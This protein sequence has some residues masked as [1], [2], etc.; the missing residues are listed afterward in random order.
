VKENYLNI[1]S[2]M[3]SSTSK[4]YLSTLVVLSRRLG[5]DDESASDDEQAEKILYF[6]PPST[7][8]ERQ[9]SRVTMIEGLIEFAGK[10]SS[11]PIDT[12]MMEKQLWSFFPAEPDVWIV[13]AVHIAPDDDMSGLTMHRADS[14][15]LDA[16]VKKLYSFI[17]TFITAGSINGHI[18]RDLERIL[19]VKQLRKRARKLRIRLRQEEQD[20]ESI[21]RHEEAKS[22]KLNEN[23]G[24]DVGPIDLE[25]GEENA[26]D[27]REEIDV[28]HQNPS[29]DVKGAEAYAT[30]LSDEAEG[31]NRESSNT[32]GPREDG[33]AGLE[34]EVVEDKEE[35]EEELQQQVQPTEE[36]EAEESLEDEHLGIRAGT[37]SLVEI[38]K[39]I[40]ETSAEILAA[41]EGVSLMVTDCYVISLLKSK[42]E[43][44]LNWYVRTGEMMSPSFSTACRGMHYASVPD[45]ALSRLLQI[46]YRLQDELKE[47]FLGFSVLMNGQLAWHEIP[48]D[49]EFQTLYDFIRL[50]E[51]ERVRSLARNSFSPDVPNAPVNGERT[52]SSGQKLT[53]TDIA[54][55]KLFAPATGKGGRNSSNILQ[56]FDVK[57]QEYLESL[58][59][60]SGFISSYWQDI[61]HPSDIFDNS[62]TR[63]S[64]NADILD[65]T[66][67]GTGIKIW[68]PSLFAMTESS[69]LGD[70]A[71]G[72]PRIVL[73]RHGRFIAITMLSGDLFARL[74][75]E[76]TSEGN[77]MSETKYSI[78]EILMT[79][80]RIYEDSFPALQSMLDDASKMS[81]HTINTKLSSAPSSKQTVTPTVR[82]FYH[83]LCGTATKVGY[84]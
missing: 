79:L 21:R 31:V 30:S 25:N 41:E 59:L 12:V 84:I 52:Y 5:C 55:R 77:S 6:Y 62:F 65:W 28:G 83:N 61:D 75:D 76:A 73:F 53:A 60:S 23:D 48:G 45:G 16:V 78:F 15:G 63:A 70:N 56:L 82:I 7:P 34:G 35:E 1:I 3:S 50:Q 27:I 2:L 43:Y 40:Q 17:Y 44:F 81:A 13:A 32:S 58:L 72:A 49:T 4:L 22:S 71:R 80:K 66:S 33:G 19:A 68:C 64:S 57:A 11:D 47:R 29:E 54:I 20:Y 18:D 67:I 9:L 14:L 26:Q 36:C 74:A 69:L 10:F 42:L 38:Q 24:P 37:M 46:K 39:Q 8:L 51:A